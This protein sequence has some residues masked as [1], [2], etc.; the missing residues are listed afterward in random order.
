[1]EETT[2]LKKTIFGAIVIMS[3][4]VQAVSAGGK[5]YIQEHF[6]DTAAKVKATTDPVQKRELL[7]KSIQTITEALE[8]VKSSPLISEEDRA[9]IDQFK[10]ILQE[11]QDELTGSNGYQPVADNQLN[12]FSDYVV[13]NVEQA[14]RTITI[15]V[16]TALLIIIIIIL[17]T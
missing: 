16:V 7:T 11:N 14:D 9:G 8:Q 1:M 12:A 17:I 15:S 5:N 2:M 13:Q 3:M 6:N 10:V 4:L